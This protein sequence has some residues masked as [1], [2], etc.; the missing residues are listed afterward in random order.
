VTHTIP[1]D[2]LYI[3]TRWLYCVQCPQYS[4]RLK[5]LAYVYVSSN[6]MW[7]GPRRTSIPNG[8]LIH[9]AIWRQ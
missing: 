8:I 4:T 5:A 9:P 3:L 2:H 7:S 1:E 6:T